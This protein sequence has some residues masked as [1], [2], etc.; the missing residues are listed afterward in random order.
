MMRSHSAVLQPY[1]PTRSRPFNLRRAN[2]ILTRGGFGAPLDHVREVARDGVDA[3][4]AYLQNP[5]RDLGQVASARE[6]QASALER[7]QAWWIERMLSGEAALQERVTLIWHG[8]FAV[9]AL[10]TKAI[11]LSLGQYELL[12]ARGL[13]SFADLLTLAVHDPAMLVYLDGVLNSKSRPN[14]NVA[15]EVL[16]LF[17]LGHGNYTQRDVRELARALTGWTV[18]LG[19]ARLRPEIHDASEKELLGSRG[20]FSSQEAMR[21][22][23]NHP[24]CA[25]RVCGML[26]RE[27]IGPVEDP[28]LDQLADSLRADDMHIGR[29]IERLLRSREFLEPDELPPRIPAPVELLVVMSRRLGLRPPGLTLARLASRMGQ[30]LFAPPSVAGWP[31]GERWL[32]TAWRVRRMESPAV[33]LHES[34]VEVD[35]LGLLTHAPDLWGCTHD[36]AEVARGAVASVSDLDPEA[37]LACVLALPELQWL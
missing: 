12:R 25:R 18:V 35:A 28:Q 4:F 11:G 31:R 30:Q 21:V 22:V 1:A 13:G 32:S 36:A 29:W 19:E 34:N 2:R 16:E 26:W 5:A 27:F 3:A 24:E 10:E 14:E 23:A 15:R 17:A 6:L 33:V 9:S 20:S 7:A 37:A 8:H